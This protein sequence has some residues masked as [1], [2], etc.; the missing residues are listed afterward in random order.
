MASLIESAASE[1]TQVSEKIEEIKSSVALVK[2]GLTT[3]I[4][5]LAVS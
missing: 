1:K 4:D 2:T 5:H 3:K